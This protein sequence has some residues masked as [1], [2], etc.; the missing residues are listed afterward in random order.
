MTPKKVILSCV[1]A[2]VLLSSNLVYAMNH[3]TP[4]GGLPHVVITIPAVLP[5][6]APTLV[7]GSSPPTYSSSVI[8]GISVIAA[9][10]CFLVILGIILGFRIT[11]DI[12]NRSLGG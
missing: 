3:P 7:V 11:E 6:P 1:V 9:I 2:L 8:P 5:A 4:G 10:C 12:A